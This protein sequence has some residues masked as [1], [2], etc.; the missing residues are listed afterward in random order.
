MDAGV[1]L[2]RG[3]VQ[4]Q[5]VR[6]A[7]Q[8]REPVLGILQRHAAHDAVHLVALLEQKLRQIGA[9]LPRDARDQRAPGR[10]RNRW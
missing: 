1:A 9:V 5:A 7:A 3:R 10:H 4:V 8:A 2:E 6:E